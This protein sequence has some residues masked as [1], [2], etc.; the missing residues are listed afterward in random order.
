MITRVPKRRGEP[1]PVLPP[2]ARDKSVQTVSTKKD[3]LRRSL[4]VL[5]AVSF[6]FVVIGGQ[7]VRLGLQAKPEVRTS[8]AEPVGRNFSR[9]DITD[10]QGRLLATDIEVHSL[11]ADPAL[12]LDAD[13]ASEKLS[14]LF[15][16]LVAADVRRQ[17]ADPSRRFVWLKRG[18]SPARARQVHELGLPGLGF[19]KELRRV[20]PMGEGAGHVLGAVNIDNKGVSGLERAIDDAGAAESV[21]GTARTPK[22]PWVTS[23]DIGIQHGVEQELAA[24]LP[25]YGARAAA[26]LV[27]DA[28]T[29]EIVAAVSVPGVDPTRPSDAMDPAR[30]DRL[31]AGTYE[32]GSI[33]KSL[34]IAD[35]LDAGV[36]TLDTLVD[37]RQPLQAGPFTIRDLHPQGRPLSVRDV[38]LHSSNV[39]AAMI[40]LKSGAGHQREF[41]T[42][43]GLTQSLRLET[44][45]V[46]SPQVP[47]RWDRIE[48][49]TISYGHGLAVAPIQFAAALAALVN[50]GY[51]VSPTFLVREAAAK[52][53]A[54]ALISSAASA[55]MRELMRLNVTHAS[56]TG[57]RADA[58]GYRVGGKTGTAEMASQGGYTKKSVISSF[59]AAFPMDAPRYVMLVMLFEPQGQDETKGQITAGVNA[60]PV[61]GRIVARIAPGLGVLPRRVADPEMTPSVAP[62]VAFDGTRDAQ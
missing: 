12:I 52:A 54:V 37:V 57:R 48:T 33:F 56:G 6:G 31:M 5:A 26:G 55:R 2:S 50:G 30:I 8:L 3:A 16:D 46:A 21:L 36:V 59:A 43:L 35:A 32:L 29:G 28:V 9:P 11:Y 58:E 18:L 60:A 17:L 13:E 40:A 42:R 24:A 7:L 53:P 61:A 25:R 1:L 27:M 39:G 4:G 14:A 62:P 20:Y 45:P 51:K 41:L 47:S 22:S 10:R 44:G 19:R 38:F 15:P 34:T 49:I 23:I